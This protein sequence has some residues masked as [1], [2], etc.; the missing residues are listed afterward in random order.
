MHWAD[1]GG[2]SD[3]KPR[4]VWL[5]VACDIQSKQAYGRYSQCKDGDNLFSEGKEFF[6]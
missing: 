5:G 4:N 1:L 3:G 2:I 6:T